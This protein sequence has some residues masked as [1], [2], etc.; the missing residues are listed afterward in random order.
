DY[1]VPETK[2]QLPQQVNGKKAGDFRGRGYSEWWLILRIKRVGKRIA[3]M[4]NGEQ[5]SMLNL[6]L[7]L[8]LLYV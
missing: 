3:N 1:L 2:Q 8:Y 6:K 7:V 5:M 4:L